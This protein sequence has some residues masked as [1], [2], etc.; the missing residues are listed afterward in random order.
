MEYEYSPLIILYCLFW[1]SLFPLYFYIIYPL[2]IRFLYNFHIYLYTFT[3]FSNCFISEW[4]VSTHVVF[5]PGRVGYGHW[6]TPENSSA[7]VTTPPGCQKNMFS[8]MQT[9]SLYPS[10]PPCILQDARKSLQIHKSNNTETSQ[11]NH[12]V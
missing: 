7:F 3:I 9:I 11:T 4:R 10:I 1:F 5:F 6:T 2:F 12:C 8:K